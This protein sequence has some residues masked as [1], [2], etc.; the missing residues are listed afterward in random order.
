MSVYKEYLDKMQ[1]SLTGE[2]ILEIAKR[3][4]VKKPIRKVYAALAITAAVFITGTVT[5]GAACNWDFKSLLMNDYSRS[6]HELSQVNE[7]RAGREQEPFM[8]EGTVKYP[9]GI[10]IYHEL[11]EKELDLLDRVTIPVGKTFETDEHI[12]TV[13][14]IIYDGYIIGINYTI[15]KKEGTFSDIYECGD[16]D[17]YFNYSFYDIN[18]NDLSKHGWIGGSNGNGIDTSSVSG[19][20]YTIADDN[21]DLKKLTF[22]IGHAYTDSSSFTSYPKCGEFTVELPEVSDLSEKYALDTEAY[23]GGYGYSR[24]NTV[25]FSPSGVIVDFDFNLYGD[26]KDTDNIYLNA[27]PI[28]LTMNNETVIEQNLSGFRKALTVNNDGSFHCTWQLVQKYYLIDAF[29]VAAVQIGNE[30]IELDDS[31]IIED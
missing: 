3:G 12:L 10:E 17:H 15:G 27:P 23:L 16:T 13:H 7:Y 19:T 30:Y 8:Y 14:G 31:M 11:S 6:R 1:S 4:R 28:F 24:L 21:Y 26:I 9:K 20:K 29:N 22:N 2:E 25:T 18:G 5:V